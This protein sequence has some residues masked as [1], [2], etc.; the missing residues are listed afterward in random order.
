MKADR[1][2]SIDLASAVR[3]SGPNITPESS[4]LKGRLYSEEAVHEKDLLEQAMRDII[5]N[6]LVRNQRRKR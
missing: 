1:Q 6:D 2:R 4:I 3:Q 5:L